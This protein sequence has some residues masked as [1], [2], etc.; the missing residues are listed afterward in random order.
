MGSEVII[1]GDSHGASFDGPTKESGRQTHWDPKLKV[2]QF[3]H[4][5]H[6]GI[7]PVDEDKSTD[8]AP[9]YDGDRAQFITLNRWACNELIKAVR[10]GRDQSYGKDE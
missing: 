5:V 7:F 10:K 1:Y 6:I 8:D 9:I 4:R 2:R 3:A